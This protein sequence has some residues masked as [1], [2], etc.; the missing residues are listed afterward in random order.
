MV[1]LALA[2]LSAFPLN[3][4]TRLTGCL[5]HSQISNGYDANITRFPHSVLVAYF[6]KKEDEVFEMTSYGGA[7][8]IKPR[9]IVSTAHVLTAQEGVDILKKVK[10]K[11]IFGVDQ[12]SETNFITDI[13]FY[14]SHPKFK[15]EHNIAYDIAIGRLR[16]A[17]PM[18]DRIQPIALASTIDERPFRKYN[19][20][21]WVTGFGSTEPDY[22]STV[23]GIDYPRLRYMD[24]K[25]TTKETCAKKLRYELSPLLCVHRGGRAK[26]VGGCGGDSG[27]G[28]IGFGTDKNESVLLG[29]TSFVTGTCRRQFTF[30][31]TV[32]HYT[33]WIN[34]AMGPE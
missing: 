12:F 19:K 30:F 22:K 31:S 14:V 32:S 5:P 7:S 29:I 33:G 3:V 10:P 13:E 23:K 15:P 28:L 2:V 20:T 11:A 21:L 34:Q 17:P 27:S 6:E 8:L 9:W 24:V 16:E 26:R 25:L 1:L 4:N 18:S